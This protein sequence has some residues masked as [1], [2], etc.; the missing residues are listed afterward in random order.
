MTH[1]VSERERLEKEKEAIELDKREARCNSHVF[2]RDMFLIPSQR[3]RRRK[4]L[5]R[6][7]RD[8]EA[9]EREEELEVCRDPAS[10]RTWF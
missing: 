7:Q 9:R 8:K 4:E 2:R 3:E 5:E 1:V 10:N 6:E